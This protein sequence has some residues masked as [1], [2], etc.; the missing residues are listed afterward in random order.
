MKINILIF[1]F[2]FFFSCGKVDCDKL[3]NIYSE[4]TCKIIIKEI[5]SPQS[6]HNFF[7][8]GK[9]VLTNKDTV[10]DEENRW[11]CQ[12]YKFLNKGDTIIKNKGQT[13][14]SIHKK[15]TVYSFPFECDNRIY[16]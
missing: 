12:F 7:I 11:F 4:T 3:L 5:P 1:F 15:D 2:L 16:K 13:I 10:Y 9:T 6:G 14:F 8:K